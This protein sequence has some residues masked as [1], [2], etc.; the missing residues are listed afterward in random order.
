LSSIFFSPRTQALRSIFDDQN[1]IHSS[2]ARRVFDTTAAQAVPRFELNQCL[3]QPHIVCT[4]TWQYSQLASLN[5]GFAETANAETCRSTDVTAH[6]SARR[7]DLTW[8]TAPRSTA[9]NR[10]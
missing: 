6:P 9:E 7:T 3:G 1:N 8:A 2:V 5:G 10:F 4:Y